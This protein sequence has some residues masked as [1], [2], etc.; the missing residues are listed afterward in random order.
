MASMSDKVVG[1]G[2]ADM[3]FARLAMENLEHFGS[4]ATDYKIRCCSRLG[5]HL[6]RL[7][8]STHSVSASMKMM[9][10]KEFDVIAIWVQRTLEVLFE[11]SKHAGEAFSSSVTIPFSLG[12]HGNGNENH[13][14][15]DGGDVLFDN[16]VFAY[17]SEF[18]STRLK[19]EL[20]LVEG[21]DPVEM[22]YAQHERHAD[23]MMWFELAVKAL[24]EFGA[25][26]NGGIDNKSR[27]P[28]T[29]QAYHVLALVSYSNLLHTCLSV[30]S[31]IKDRKGFQS[32]VECSAKVQFL[33]QMLKHLVYDMLDNFKAGSATATGNYE[34]VYMDAL[35]DFVCNCNVI[36]ENDG[37]LSGSNSLALR[38]DPEDSDNFNDQQ[39]SFLQSGL[40]GKL[41]HVFKE[42]LLTHCMDLDDGQD[43]VGVAAGA[44]RQKVLEVQERFYEALS[45]LCTIVEAYVLRCLGK[46]SRT[47][48]ADGDGS[49]VLFVPLVEIIQEFATSDRL[50]LHSRE[51]LKTCVESIVRFTRCHELKLKVKYSSSQLATT[52]EPQQQEQEDGSQ[53]LS[54]ILDSLPPSL[55]ALP[56]DETTKAGV[57]PLLARLRLACRKAFAHPQLSPTVAD[58]TVGDIGLPRGGRNV[59]DDCKRHLLEMF[60]CKHVLSASGDLVQMRVS[61]TNISQSSTEAFGK[62]SEIHMCLQVE[63][64]NSST[65]TIDSICIHFGSTGPCRV[66]KR[67]V[68]LGNVTRGEV[69]IFEVLLDVFAFGRCS[70]APQVVLTKSTFQLKSQTPGGTAAMHF[71]T[72]G[73]LYASPTLLEHSGPSRRS[74][75]K[76]KVIEYTF[77]QLHIPMQE[78]LIKSGIQPMS[79]YVGDYKQLW[80][81]FSHEN[82]IEIPK[83]L[84]AEGLSHL[85]S[86]LQSQGFHMV[87]EPLEVFD[88]IDSK[89]DCFDFHLTAE[90]FDDH[91]LLLTVTCSR[92]VNLNRNQT[93][94][95]VRAAYAVRLQFKSSATKVMHAIQSMSG[96]LLKDI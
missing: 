48:D 66:D 70:I 15:S 73:T 75:N 41:V 26:K 44:G 64:E 94:R 76:P 82:R 37:I 13:R 39:A 88:C 51:Q 28:N 35:H 53:S 22:A 18:V 21:V 43:D 46:A 81:L 34:V 71:Y 68:E 12:L 38:D 67:M 47:T 32:S 55:L 50:D 20:V 36:M 40:L 89:R 25:Y 17:V 63:L 84:D 57:G 5:L 30:S 1:M 85:A 45:A 78:L 19:D 90:T 59:Y 72:N 69:R 92:S 54:A 33:D 9:S 24:G 29:Y 14:A 77:T 10:K 23:L 79:M 83:L 96:D 31:I 60:P 62:D 6:R 8:T 86:S 80:I 3:E 61:N 7:F 65:A 87:S 95:D 93:E 91:I 27:K 42:I 52:S 58:V 49:H 2:C 56:K 74:N 4:E 16:L 11:E